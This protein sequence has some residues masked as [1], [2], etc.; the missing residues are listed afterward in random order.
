MA[1]FKCC[2]AGEAC[3][4]AVCKAE[5]PVKNVQMFISWVL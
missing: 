4:R 1:V 2:T 3:S 5:F